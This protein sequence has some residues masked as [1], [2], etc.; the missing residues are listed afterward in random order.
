[1]LIYNDPFV[2][3]QKEYQRNIN[4]LNDYMEMGARYLSK[5]H[6]TDYEETLK[7]MKEN[8][9][10]LLHFK[11]PA[12]KAVFQ[13]N[14]GDKIEQETTLSK[15]L[16]DALVN[17]EIISPPLTTYYP[18]K[19]KKAFLVDFTLANIA[20]R[21]KN[22]K[23]MFRYEML[24]DRM[25]YLI[26]KNEQ[27]NDKI[28]NNAISG[29][30]VVPST[31]IY[32]PTMHPSLT[33]TC[34]ITSGY[35]N[36]NNEKFL[37]GNRHYYSPNIIINDL[38]SI[39]THFDHDLM[40]QV[41]EKYNIH[42][43]SAEEV[44]ALIVKCSSK[45]GRHRSKETLIRA[46]IDKLTPLERAAFV[47]IGDMYHLKEY[48]PDLVRTI[49]ARLS[50][51]HAIDRDLKDH[52]EIINKN[53]EAIYYLACQICKK[54]TIGIDTSLKET[55]ESEL[56]LLL[57]SNMVK[58]IEVLHDYSDLFIAFYRTSNM[59]TQVAHF[60]DS[61]REVVLMSDTDST[62][63]TTEDWVDW[64]LG[65]IDFT[66]T[67]NA[68]FAVMVFLSGSPLKHLLAQMS[69]NIGVD[70]DRIFL[71]SMK[72]EFKF[73][74]F[75]PTLNTKH[76]YAMITYQE[77]NIYDKPKME[78]K[79]VHLKS[80]NAPPAIIKRAQEMMKEICET[81][82]SGEKLS[83]LKYI[84]EIADTERRIMASV[85][86]GESTYYRI[87]N[88]K[89]ADAY[90]LGEDSIYKYY[91]LYNDT[92]GR[93]YGE[94]EKPPVMTYKMSTWL[95]NKT[96]FGSYI[97]SLEE[98]LRSYFKEAVKNYKLDKLP[99]FYIPVDN[100]ANQPIPEVITRTIDKRA[101]IIDICHIYYYILETLG[102]FRLNQ[103][104]TR[105]LSDEF[106]V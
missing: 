106:T 15:Y 61:I 53:P 11:D 3:P 85:D 80:S 2:K 22:K 99:T 50:E 1:M 19:K 59:P 75:V 64:F 77:G 93:I 96:K 47:Y 39:T 40:L 81:V 31:M 101:L 102:V 57:A 38:V 5:L 42:Y 95:T 76:Y 84:K 28:S 20:S 36:A 55:K 100:F 72:N 29:A 13:D 70:N 27:A 43:P 60:K 4:P 45:Y 89:D 46:Y 62:I 94:M 21:S 23:E 18:E 10:S 69:A 105:L 98:P 7:W 56:G 78:I 49:I 82:R 63:F 9:D 92:F 37:G 87:Q 73:E 79:G 83:V 25:N 71:I 68:V 66:D 26:K 88:I 104:Q 14:N 103:Y 33:S 12:V 16:N 86:Q 90:K 65:H 48:N 35:A 54:E 32:N 17:H 97:E 41:M 51:K 44:F 58:I 6:G 67:A 30:S 34:R 8:R 74:I 52:V 91:S 24:K